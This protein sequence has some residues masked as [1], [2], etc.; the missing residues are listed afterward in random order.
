VPAAM[1]CGVEHTS[2]RKRMGLNGFRFVS[3][4]DA[5]ANLNIGRHS[6]LL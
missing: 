3:F 5:K 4:R 6:K 2:Q 1:E